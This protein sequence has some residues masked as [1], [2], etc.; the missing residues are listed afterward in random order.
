MAKLTAPAYDAE[1]I[2]AER[3]ALLEK[4]RSELSTSFNLASEIDGLTL[5]ESEDGTSVMDPS[6]QA[7]TEPAM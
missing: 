6:M 5:L 1:A 7:T 3:H 4:H 2:V